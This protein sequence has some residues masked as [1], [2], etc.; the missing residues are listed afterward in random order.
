MIIRILI[1]GFVL[2]LFN[3]TY[4]QNFEKI[5]VG[6]KDSLDGYY[7]VLK[8][9]NEIHGVLV[10]FPTR[11]FPPETVFEESKLQN[12]AWSNNLLTIA[13]SAGKSFYAD[14]ASI[15]NINL[16]LNDVVERYGVK[17][18]KFVFGGF[19]GG[20]MIG[21]RYV[22]YC[23][24]YPEKFPVKPQGVFAIDPAVDYINLWKYF[25][26]ELKSG[27][28]NSGRA[29]AEHVLNEMTSNIGTLQENIEKYKELTPFYSDLEVAG[30][31]KFL[32]H[33]PIRLYYEIDM[34]W[35]LKNKRRSAYDLNFLN[36]SEMIKRLLILG[37]E[38]AEFIQ[39]KKEGYRSDGQRH[40]HSWSIIDEIDCI[41]WVKG[42][43]NE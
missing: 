32:R 11:G 21:L 42:L 25:E 19:G 1:L 29:E 38:K 36:G 27:I 3:S 12:L 40:P 4:S 6:N 15:A 37:N 10:L 30:N 16:I 35:Y 28:S 43:M 9:W 7:L 2:F 13:F 34:E 31:E 23:K 17:R 41:Q 33:I 5:V 14:S 24:E 18:D 20:G 39:A 8:P 26:R 22:E